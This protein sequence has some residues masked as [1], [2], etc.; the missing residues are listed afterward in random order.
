MLI[1]LGTLEMFGKRIV[2]WWGC[3]FSKFGIF[4]WS[5]AVKFGII[6]KGKVDWSFV[7]FY[8]NCFRVYISD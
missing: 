6:E 7:G 4:H 3:G 2:V 1:E 5:V 8:M